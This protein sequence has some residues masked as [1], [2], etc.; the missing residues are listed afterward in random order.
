MEPQTSSTPLPAAPRRSPRRQWVWLF[1]LVLLGASAYFLYPLV[2]SKLTR[3]Q[4]QDSATAPTGKKGRGAGSTPVV[5][6]KARKGN[7]G[8]Y[9]TGL[10]AVTPIYTVTVKSRVD[11]QLMEIRYKE[12]QLVHEGDLLIEIDP[13]PFQ[14]QLAQAEGQLLKDQAQLDNAKHRPGALPEA[15]GAERHSGAAAR[16]AG[17]AGHAGRRLVKTDQAQIDSAKLNLVYCHITAP[18]T[19]RVGL[20][21]V[22]PG[23]I[24][25]ATDTNGL[26]V[27]TRIEPISVIFTDR[28][29]SASAGAEENARR[30]DN[31]AWMPTIAI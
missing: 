4:A 24:V 12:G 3:A 30:P 27:I 14:V 29:R 11:G 21:L 13:R 2:N 26:L 7:I 18:I 15:A 17:R 5:A 16:H 6:A 23:N 19:G 31:C 28:R 1:V 10:G 22:D 8:V 9:I 20:R 25:H